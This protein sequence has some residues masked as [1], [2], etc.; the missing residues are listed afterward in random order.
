MATMNHFGMTLR[1][2]RERMS[3][4]DSGLEADGERRVPGLRREELEPST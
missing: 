2:W 3:P 4:Q 1:G